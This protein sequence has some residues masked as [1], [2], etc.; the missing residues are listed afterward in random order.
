[1]NVLKLIGRTTALLLGIA[2]YS[3]SPNVFAEEAKQT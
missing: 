2:I 3:I 1:M